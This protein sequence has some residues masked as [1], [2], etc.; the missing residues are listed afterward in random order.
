MNLSRRR[1]LV[2][3][4]AAVLAAPM[5][6]RAVTAQQIAPF[7]EILEAPRHNTSAFKLH[8]WQ[9]HF[10]TLRNGAILSDTK[11][12]IVQCWSEGEAVT[13]LYPT[14][15]PVSDDL[16]RLGHT[17]VVEKKRT[18][19]GGPR[20]RCASATLSGPSSCREAIR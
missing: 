1:L 12:M 6:A 8:R 17:Q 18:R 13:R 3:G 7:G 14:S 5:L 19:P 11:A 10:E 2:G 4:T 15:V 9:D 20:L 16:T